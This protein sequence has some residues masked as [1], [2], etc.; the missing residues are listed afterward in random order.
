MFKKYVKIILLTLLI[1]ILFHL[2][3]V[4]VYGQSG[5]STELGHTDSELNEKLKSLDPKDIVL[6][7]IDIQARTDSF[8]EVYLP[9]DPALRGI[10]W[11]LITFDPNIEQNH[12]FWVLAEV[13]AGKVQEISEIPW[14][15]NTTLVKTGEYARLSKNPK[16]AMHGM[17]YAI[18]RAVDEGNKS[19][20]VIV[21]VENQ[22]A[23]SRES[24]NSSNNSRD[25]ILQNVTM[26][27]NQLRG[28]VLRIG[29]YKNKLVARI[30]PLSIERITNNPY[31][32]SIYPRGPV[33]YEGGTFSEAP[34][35]KDTYYFMNSL[36]ITHCYFV[37]FGSMID[38]IT[39]KKIGRRKLTLYILIVLS[40]TAFLSVIP[41]ARALNF[42]TVTIRATEVWDTGNKGAG[43]V[44]AII[45][46]G[47]DYNH[48][49]FP[50]NAIVYNFTYGDHNIVPDDKDGH[51][52]HTAGIIAG[53]G[54][55]NPAYTGVAPEARLVM[56]K[57]RSGH[58]DDLDDAINW[59]RDNKDQYNISVL[60]LSVA[61]PGYP[62]GGDGTSV[63]SKAVD[64]AIEAGIVVVKSAG[65]S[66]PGSKT[67]TTPGDAFN[68]ISVGA[69]DDQNTESITDDTLPD[70]SSRGTT[71]DNRPKPDVVAPGVR[72]ISCRAAG[73]DI[74]EQGW[75][76]YIDN[77][78][79]ES[80]G[81]SM[82]APHVAGTVALM[83]NE[84]RDL[85]PAQV[86]AILRQTARLNNNLNGLGVNDRGHGIVDAYEAVQLAQN[87][88]DIDMSQMYDW[89]DVTTPSQVDPGG[90]SGR[91]LTFWV[92]MPAAT[93]APISIGGVEYHFWKVGGSG[94]DYLLLWS[95]YCRYVWID[96]VP[97]DLGG[98]A[99]KY[100]F[101]G[102]RIYEKGGGYVLMRAMYKVGDVFV[103]YQWKMDV[104]EM[105]LKLNFRGGSSWRALIYID[106]NVWSPMDYAS[107]PSTEETI[108]IERKICGDVLLDIR[109]RDHTEYIQIDPSS[110]DHPIMWI[111][112]GGYFGN[113][114]NTALNNQYI[115]NEDIVVYYQASSD[116]PDP[117]P[118]IHR[119][120]N[121]P[122]TPDPTQND[123]G[124]GGD[125][126]NNFNQAPLINPGSYTGILCDSDPEDTKDWYKFCAENGT[127]IEVSM[128]PPSDIDFDLELYD[129]AGNLKAGS[130]LGPGSKESVSYTADSSGYWRAKIYIQSGEALYYFSVSNQSSDEGGGC[131]IL[132]VYDG[133][134]YVSEGLLDIH[135][136]DGI[137][138]VTNHTLITTPK[139]V[140][141]EYLLQLTEHPQTISHIDQVMLFAILEDKTL[142]ELPLTSAIHSDYDDVLPQLLSCDDWKTDTFGA[143][144]NN[145]TSQSIDLRFQAP[146]P[147][148]KT[149]GFVFQI[150]GN[151]MLIK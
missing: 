104:N 70:F 14:V 133:K 22:T 24:T 149:I 56:I 13:K 20:E 151:N 86:K 122:F 141:D 87:V 147:N 10:R 50:D 107:L 43:V 128:T 100:L 35:I 51:G 108:K 91:Y 19:L 38:F 90:L 106:T 47:I 32:L 121:P 114:P 94:R 48:N 69:I 148:I 17:D 64:D 30:S 80:S 57:L 29:P 113:N 1:V 92:A 41:F 145:G 46:S 12:Q 130:Y 37:I 99:N 143:N 112:K 144:F 115:Y 7:W 31:V 58:G 142:I 132:Y 116:I 36:A 39:V 67:I 126:S 21:Y 55:A 42:S 6:V 60:S 25:T 61:A 5:L 44:V 78:Y 81:T 89:W 18:Q 150:E 74:R 146:P 2:T 72:I 109:D 137:D 101:S 124:T 85:T 16:F 98:E 125:A 62:T 134:E 119:K 26:L 65:N 28:K 97:Y 63:Y 95:I 102:P 118:S 40:S 8:N 33:I 76:T 77:D 135:D 129:P 54:I 123:A 111:L 9:E 103:E 138:V 73:T 120:T 23:P 83:L 96:Y 79:V 34:K 139:P 131:P 68:V 110:T 4:N 117:G 127:S 45:D 15:K 84:N 49:D 52:T 88:A 82:A 136:P 59:V 71:G 11:I 105:W 27:I 75:D 53:R 66:G 93:S 3:Q 140:N